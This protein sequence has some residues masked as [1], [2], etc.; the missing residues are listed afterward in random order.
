MKNLIKNYSSSLILLLSILIGGIIGAV[1]GP[2][3]S[4]LEPLG[5]IFL[6]LIF[7]LIVP[8]VF[9]SVASSIA[10]MG[11]MG[12]LG[13]ILINIVIVFVATAV[14]SALISIIAVYIVNPTE[15]LDEQ[16]IENILKDSDEDI[17]EDTKNISIANQLV[18]AIT[19]GDFSELFTK[20]NML[21]LI[22]ISVIFGLA[23]VMAGEKAEVVKDFLNAC[24]EIMMKM[25]KII[26]YYAP[27]GLACF[28]ASLTGQLGTQ[29]LEGY[30]KVFLL[31][32]GLTVIYY[33]GFFSI[34]AYVAG[35]GTAVKAFWKNA[36]APAVTALAT[37]SS[38]ASIPVNLDAAKNIGIPD[39]IAETVIPLGVNTHKDGSVIG[40][41][42]KIVFL[43]GLFGKDF[44]N[45]PMFFSVLI[46]SLL[47]GAVMGAI[48]GGGMIGEMLILSVYG[49]P[50]AAFPVLAVIGT[51]IDAP[52]TLLN[53]SGNTVCAMLVARF[54]DGK[55]W[56]KGNKNK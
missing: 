36:I 40:G 7:T 6:N 56:I 8:L 38:A 14:I 4:V 44:N 16:A 3:A 30:V 41:V 29:I 39:D 55:N 50:P 48:P 11:K 54:V 20:S 15:G 53:A 52:A 46:V 21:P 43:F 37:C 5:Q 1:M 27:I 24:S 51:I 32:I 28:F 19:V 2:E 12:R 45:L 10:N 49:F 35:K 17:S 42:L 18:K 33:F 26:M 13:K 25:I 34:Y 31:Y 22:V 23:I 47:V 9:F